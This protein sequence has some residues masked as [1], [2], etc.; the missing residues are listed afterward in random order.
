MP[1]PS[2]VVIE[3][4]LRASWSLD[5]CDRSDVDDWTP[6]NP[7]RGQCGATSLVLLDLFGGELLMA[8]VHYPDGGHQGVHYWV[9]LAGGL[10]MDLT[11][12]QFAPNEM[13]QEPYVVSR[14]TGTTWTGREQY[15]LLRE[16]TEAALRRAAGGPVA[17]H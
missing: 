14:P 16:Q 15:L 7:S 5:T 3:E 13:V 12:Q 8:E 4:A 6:E 9:R 1:L 17:F 2:L 10:E 11:R